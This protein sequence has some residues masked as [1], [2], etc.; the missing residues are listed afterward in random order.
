[1]SVTI[2]RLPAR[3]RPL[4]HGVLEADGTEQ[5]LVEYVGVGVVEGYID[6]SEMEAGDEIV[7][8]QYIRVN[9]QAKYK[10]Y[11][12]ETYTGKQADPALYITPKPCDYALKITLQQTKGIFRRF[13]Y[14]FMVES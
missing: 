6:L 7:V 11:A 14:N 9:S 13:T 2:T 1:L 4:A 5:T 3:L 8:A 12:L 10:R